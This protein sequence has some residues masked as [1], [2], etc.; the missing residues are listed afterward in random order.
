MNPSKWDIP[1]EILARSVFG[2]LGGIVE[3]GAVAA[4][5][6]WDLADVS[7]R[8]FVSER[9]GDVAR[10]LEVVREV[11][12]FG[13]A[14]MG[15]FDEL[16][17]LREHPVE[18]PSLLLWSSGY[19][20]VWR[21]FDHPGAVRRMSRVGADLQLT[22]FLDAMVDAAIARGPAVARG[23]ALIAEALQIAVELAGA[24]VD[25][26]RG[27]FTVLRMWRTSRL[28]DLLLPDSP[29]RPEARVLFREYGHALD[30]LLDALLAAPGAPGPP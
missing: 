25:D 22:R 12:D 16:G 24:A 4:T 26:A 18:A 1:E 15:I 30:A 13:E 7:V 19:E 8:E 10:L 29:A 14:V 17:Y 28:A 2:P 6:T 21:P 20:D 23:A 9:R 3:V 11:G 27:A 5:G